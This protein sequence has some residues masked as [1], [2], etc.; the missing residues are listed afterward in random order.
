MKKIARILAVS[1]LFFNAEVFAELSV[2]KCT[3]TLTVDAFTTNAQAPVNTIPATITFEPDTYT[4][5]GREFAKAFKPVQRGANLTLAQGVTR[6]T[7]RAGGT[8]RVN[9]I[10]STEI[11]SDG[12]GKFTEEWIVEGVANTAG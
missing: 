10:N 8:Y 2:M 4:C 7:L 3:G 9:Y 12:S 5:I 6:E 11:P 1:T